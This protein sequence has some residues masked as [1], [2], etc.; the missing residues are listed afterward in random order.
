MIDISM[1]AAMATGVL[2]LVVSGFGIKYY[3]KYKQIMTVMEHSALFVAGVSDVIAYATKA[4]ED[5]Q[6]SPDEVK[7][8]KA[9]LEL[10]LAYLEELQE[11]LKK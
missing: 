3:G 6:I 9:R 1:I 11:L 8:V 2:T 10:V 5:D 4:L 7:D